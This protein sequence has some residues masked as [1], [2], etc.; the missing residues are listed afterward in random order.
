MEVLFSPNIHLTKLSSFEQMGFS[1][2]LGFYP[3]SKPQ[4][5]NQQ[6]SYPNH[7]LLLGFGC[8]VESIEKWGSGA[9][10]NDTALTLHAIP[11][12]SCL[13]S[14]PHFEKAFT[15]TMGV[16]PKALF[17]L[18][19]FSSFFSS[20]SLHFG[21]SPSPSPSFPPIF[22]TSPYLQGAET[23]QVAS[24]SYLYLM[25]PPCLFQLG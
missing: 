1:E 4:K 7:H 10:A 5:A 23:A 17:F 9:V 20:L 3:K 15:I 8:S 11:T 19:F 13:I 18:S 16:T 21:H 25:S 24:S 14:C 2:V 12:L 22:M 6:I